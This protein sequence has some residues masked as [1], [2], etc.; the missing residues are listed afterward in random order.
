MTAS[1][2]YQPRRE[3]RQVRQRIRGIDYHVYEWG[4]RG[5]PLIVMLHGWGDSGGSFQFLVDELES[6]RFVVAPDWRGFGRTHHRAESYWFPDY[7]ADLDRLIAIY[8]PDT[9]VTLLGHS[10]GGNVAGLFAGAFP[11]RV[12]HFINVEGFGLRES[13]P[14]ETPLHFRRWIE[15]GRSSPAYRDYESLDELAARIH[16]R[17]PQMS[18][19]QANFVAGLWAE[20]DGNGRFSLRADPAHKLPNAIQYRRA[21]AEACWAAIEAPV[22]LVSGADTEFKDGVQAWLD[23]AK[24]TGLSS[25]TRHEVIADAGHMIHFEQPQALAR[26]TEAFLTA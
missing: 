16:Q 4:D 25:R 15:K 24:N 2:I 5:D 26:A 22:Q 6:D 17:S 10:M 21:E 8:S 18:R 20:A 23:S 12:S 19:A 3:S 11:E 14:A 7:V 9:P 1:Q 13:D